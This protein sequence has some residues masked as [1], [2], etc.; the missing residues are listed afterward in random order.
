MEIRYQPQLP[1]NYR[2]PIGL[3]GCGGITKH[4]LT[5]YRAGGLDVVAMCDVDASLAAARRDEFYP[6]AAV[7]E[8]A[9]D[10]FER[11][12]IEVVDIATHPAERPPLI[13]AALRAGK[14]VLSQKPFVLDLDEGEALSFLFEN[15][16]SVMNH[17]N[18]AT[19]LRLFNSE[20]DARKR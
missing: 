5:A 2:P 13:R 3:I 17:D 10:I 11:D 16:N 6:Q 15:F 4:H 9:E 8:R 20:L 14:H 1:D 12:D 19:R 18:L 7:S